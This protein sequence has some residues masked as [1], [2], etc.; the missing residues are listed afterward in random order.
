MCITDVLKKDVRIDLSSIFFAMGGFALDWILFGCF[1][2]LCWVFFSLRILSNKIPTPHPTSPPNY[3]FSVDISLKARKTY[4]HLN[5]WKCACSVERWGDF[6]LYQSYQVYHFHCITPLVLS[7]LVC[8][9][10][11]FAIRLFR[12]ILGI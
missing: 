7:P 12:I 4:I 5:I 1:F 9:P 10:Q 6:V 8:C 3:H 2:L 11:I